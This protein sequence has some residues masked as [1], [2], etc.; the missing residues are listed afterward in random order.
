MHTADVAFELTEV[1]TGPYARKPLLASG[2]T[3]TG[4][5]EAFRAEL[6]QVLDDMAGEV[7]ARKRA[8]ARR[9]QGELSK[10]WGEGESAR[11]A[12]SSLVDNYG[13]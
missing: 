9:M 6:K 2:K 13:L 4:T 12:F 1:R 5:L 3:P 10:A 8:N 11:R 7:G